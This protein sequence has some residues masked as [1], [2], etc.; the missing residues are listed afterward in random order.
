MLL[1][2]NRHA[3]TTFLRAK[4][5]LSQTYMGNVYPCR[6][7]E[8]LPWRDIHYVRLAGDGCPDFIAMR[9]FGVTGDTALSGTWRK[10]GTALSARCCRWDSRLRPG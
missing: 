10:R 6:G 4:P 9:E 1:C 5:G 2:L 8:E 7:M 3:G